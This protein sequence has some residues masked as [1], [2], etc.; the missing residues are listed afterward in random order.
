MIIQAMLRSLLRLAALPLLG[1]LPGMVA[2]QDEDVRAVFAA[3]YAAPT[4]ATTEDSAALRAYPLYPWLQAA[5]L[6]AA[7]EFA[8]PDGE[9]QAQAIAFADAAGEVAHVR[10]LRRA[11]LTAAAERGDSAQFMSLWRDYVANDTL[12]CQR[13]DARRLTGDTATLANEIAERWVNEATLPEACNNALT[14]LKSQPLYT[15]P[16]VERRLRTRLLD[17]DMSRARELI[18]ALPAER[19]ARYQAWLRQ[20]ESPA[21]EFKNLAR[22]TPQLLDG[23]GLADSWSRWARKSPT[24]AAALLNTFASAQRL[25]DVQTQ[26]LQR[27]T[28]LALAWAR[29]PAAVALFKQVP[30]AVQDE[31]SYE[32]RVRAALWAGDWNQAFNWLALLPE[33]LSSQ[34]RWRYWNARALEAVGQ[35]SEALQRYRALMLENDPYGLLAA[36]RVGKGWTPIDEPNPI[37]PEQHAALVATPAFVRASEAWRAGL[38]S[39]ASLEWADTLNTAPAAAQ[40]TLIR[41]AAALGWHDQVMVTATRLGQFRDLDVLFPRPYAELALPAAKAAD[42]P[43]N[44]LYGVMRRESAFKPDA[45]SG[46]GAIGLLQMLPG[47]AAMT[48]KAAELPVPTAEQL[49]DP[50][51]NLPL[52]ALHLRE[53]LDKSDGRWPLTLAA[54]NAG[55]RAMSRWRPPSTMDADIWIENIPFNE[56]RSYVQRILFHVGV[57]QWLATQKPVRPNSWLQPV[58]PTPAAAP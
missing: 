35:K 41:E 25:S 24:D 42:I 56:T 44:W 4:T 7:L 34:P 47:T 52:G 26:T 33:N 13:L 38:K 55:F 27:N 31:R 40:P 28:A 58:E 5:R 39:I 2:A 29:E 46:A 57:Y 49:K 20:L 32:W 50:S 37:T 54:Y 22:R 45:T 16:L 53:L 6:K 9:A 10:D 51:I 15:A 36:G 48:A 18:P 8:D 11:L 30:E 1:L 21:E 12:S 14:W 3:A 19:Q 17:G 23:E 43:A